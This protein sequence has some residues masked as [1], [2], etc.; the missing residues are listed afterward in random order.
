MGYRKLLTI[1]TIVGSIASIIALI[2]VFLPKHNISTL[3]I[4]YIS[5]ENLTDIEKNNEP[6]FTTNFEYKKQPINRLWK[7]NIELLNTS[8]KTFVGKGKLQNMLVDTLQFFLRPGFQIIDKK[9]I[10]GDFEH[11]FGVKSNDTIQITFAQWRQNE[12]IKYSLYIKSDTINQ[13]AEDLFYQPKERQLLD[14]EMRFIKSENKDNDTLVTDAFPKQIKKAVYIIILI[15]LGLM[16]FV[17]FGILV[18]NPIG[19][20]KRISWLKNYRPA[21]QD[22]IDKE[23]EKNKELRKKYKYNPENFYNWTKF[24]YPKYPN[25]LM[26]DFGSKNFSSFLLAMIFSIVFQ[27]SMII[28]FIDLIEFFP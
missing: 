2:I 20:S 13:I 12:S 25:D 23:F 8:D 16:I 15:F 18:M 7:V 24:S 3:D 9:K 6:E 22:F 14:G 5:I 21:Y 26:F 28:I 27:F 17:F 11:W 19:F 10:S 4:K 1:L